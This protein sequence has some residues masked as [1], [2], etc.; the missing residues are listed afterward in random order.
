MFPCDLLLLYSTSENGTCHVKTSNLDGETNL[1][2]FFYVEF[3]KDNIMLIFLLKLRSVPKTFPH[4][5]NERELFDLRGV[6]K[7][8]KPNNSLYDFKGTLFVNGQ[9]W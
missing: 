1:K 6:I 4:I 3:E 2:V 7:C 5:S 9:Q 8:D